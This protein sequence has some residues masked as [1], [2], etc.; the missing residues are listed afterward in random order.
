MSMPAAD[1][2][3]RGP[4]R[5]SPAEL[6]GFFLL[7][8]VVWIGLMRPLAGSDFVDYADIGAATTPWVRQ[9]VIGL[10][11]V[12]VL[13]VAFITRK[14]W[15]Q[16]LLHEQ[17]RLR[18]WWAFPPIVLVA[19]AG[20][21]RFATQGLSDAPADW[22]VGFTVTMAL[23]GLTEE[24]S[25]RGI[26][27]VGGRQVLDTEV[28][29]WL[30]SSVLF[31]LFHLPNALVGQALVPSVAQVFQTALIGSVI[32]LLRRASGSLVVAAVFHAAY[33]WLLLQGAFA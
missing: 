25:F 19:A 5:T 2:T 21:V 18:A 29:A 22:W 3:A 7:H 12:L 4:A 28:K 31:G 10:V 13:Q 17:T 27:L 20:L 6:I 11:V 14:R 30:F 24:L 32:Y 8:V 15:W 23:V 9:F 16:P 33:D 26:L 1:T